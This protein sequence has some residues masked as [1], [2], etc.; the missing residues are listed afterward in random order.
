MFAGER[1]ELGKVGME[2]RL[3]EIVQED[4]LLT[5]FSHQPHRFLEGLGRHQ[6][7][8]P[9]LRWMRTVGAGEIA[10]VRDFD[11]IDLHRGNRCVMAPV[12]AGAPIDS[13][14]DAESIRGQRRLVPLATAANKGWAAS[15]SK[16]SGRNLRLARLATPTTAQS[17]LRFDSHI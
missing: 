3:A 4:A 5:T 6:P 17:P 9:N 2:E 10:Q 11:L 15:G 16:E 12:A 7:L 14:F 1:D 8:R 13:G